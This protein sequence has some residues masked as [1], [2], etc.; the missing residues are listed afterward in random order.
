MQEVILTILI[1]HQRIHI[2]EKPF[3]CL[4]CKKKYL[5]E[6]S[7]DSYRLG[8]EIIMK[9]VVSM[10]NLKK[11]SLFQAQQMNKHV[12]IFLSLLFSAA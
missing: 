8:A 2:G 10:K 9:E 5:E 7:K 1:T 3:E 12:F 6:P 4:I 11:N